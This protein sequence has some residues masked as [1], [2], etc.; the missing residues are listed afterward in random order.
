MEERHVLDVVRKYRKLFEERGV[1]KQAWTDHDR[2]PDSPADML[3]DAHAMLDHVERFTRSAF[4]VRPRLDRGRSHF[5]DL[6][7]ES[8]TMGHALYLLGWVQHAL[9]TAGYRS[10]NQ[11]LN[12]QRGARP[13]LEFTMM[14]INPYQTVSVL[15]D[16]DD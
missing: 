5:Q 10:M 12:D 13:W 2:C 9:W 7:A 16:G 15:D 14:Q 8:E 1:P 3:A 4:E 11:L 6:A